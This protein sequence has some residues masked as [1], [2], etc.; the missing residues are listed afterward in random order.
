MITVLSKT[1]VKKILRQLK[2]QFGIEDFG[3]DY[4]FT[5]SSKDRIFVVNKDLEKINLSDYNINTAGLYIAKEEIDGVRLT[6]EGS[7][8]LGPKAT[9]NVLVLDNA[10]DWLRGKN[11]EIESEMKGYVI[12][13]HCKDFLGCGRINKKRLQNFIP[14]ARRLGEVAPS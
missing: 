7:Q 9:K 8:I 14:K 11:I 1:D 10:E 3:L 5:K 2:A 13:K 6:I 4:I 12:V